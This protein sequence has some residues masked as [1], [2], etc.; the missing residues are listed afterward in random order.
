M[1]KKEKREYLFN[2]ELGGKIEYIKDRVKKWDVEEKNKHYK[3]YKAFAMTAMMTALGWFGYVAL[4]N[5]E[6]VEECASIAFNTSSKYASVAYDS[7]RKFLNDLPSNVRTIYYNTRLHQIPG[8]LNEEYTNT[9]PDGTKS[10]FKP[11]EYLTDS[12]GI[13]Y[14]MDKDGTVC[15]LPKETKFAKRADGRI[16]ALPKETPNTGVIAGS[17]NTNDIQTQGSGDYSYNTGTTWSDPNKKNKY[18]GGSNSNNS[19][20]FGTGGSAAGGTNQTKKVP[21]GTLFEAKSLMCIKK[22]PNGTLFHFKPE[23]YV[24]TSKGVT[25]VRDDIDEK[26]YELHHD[27]TISEKPTNDEEVIWIN[28]VHQS[29]DHSEDY[30]EFPKNK[31]GSGERFYA[32]DS[33]VSMCIRKEK[34]GVM[35]YFNP[36]G[37]S[38]NSRGTTFVRDIKGKKFY[39]L[40]HDGIISNN[41]T[42][43]K[44]VNLFAGVKE[45]FDHSQDH[46]VTIV[47]NSNSHHSESHHFNKKKSNPKKSNP[48]GLQQVFGDLNKQYA[49]KNEKGDFVYFTPRKYL[50]NEGTTFVRADN[51]HLYPLEEIVKITKRANKAAQTPTI[52]AKPTKIPSQNY[53]DDEGYDGDTN[54]SN[55]YMP[56]Q[57]QYDEREQS[58]PE[59]NQQQDSWTRVEGNPN[60]NYTVH[61]NGTT[62]TFKPREYLINNSTGRLFVVDDG[63]VTID[64]SRAK[65]LYHASPNEWTVIPADQNRLF[66]RRNHDGTIIRFWTT[67][68]YINNSTGVTYIYDPEGLF[69]EIRPR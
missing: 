31:G 56:Q 60:A 51:N 16:Y 27:G 44:G 42:N 69:T 5:K 39:E 17:K 36:D 34:K 12:N 35:R 50:E 6:T 55:T 24:V 63:G 59:T 2:D 3:R 68:Y 54:V 26:F 43:E 23:G 7:S 19:Y 8:D 28:N 4:H 1:A 45:Y 14:L 67:K 13:V 47:D 57:E 9:H 58:Y 25:Y 32:K 48:Y 38:V 61:R 52:R 22:G 64:V 66:A 40:H 10:D 37:Y 18:N 65:D 41:P 62:H 53:I 11:K 21:P 20:D 46:S 15:A 30:F 29:V 33:P 49:R